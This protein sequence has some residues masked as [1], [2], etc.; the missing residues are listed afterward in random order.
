VLARQAA[1]PSPLAARRW[2]I[3]V[4]ATAV[5]AYALDAMATVAGILLA[6]AQVLQGIG[7]WPLLAALAG[8]YAAW[9]AGLRV[10][11]RANGALL[12]KTGTS[13]NALSKAAYD[14]AT[15]RSLGVNAR[16]LAAAAGYVATEL[17]KEAP[18][19]AGAFGAAVVSDSVASADAIV[20]L[21]GAN[22]GAAVYEYALARGT[23]VVLRRVPGS[24]ADPCAPPIAAAAD[25]AAAVDGYAS[26]DDDWRP[27]EYLAD[28]Y[29][30]V[31]PDEI[32]TI[33]YFVDAM[34][35]VEP[36][37]PVLLFGVGPTLHHVFLA[38]EHASE[39]HLAD[40]LP[41][42]L[43]EIRR[44]IDRDPR[45]HDWRPFVRYTLMCEGDPDPSGADVTR[46][47][48]LT[49]SRIT[50]LLPADARRAHPLGEPATYATVISAYCADSATADRAEWAAFMDRISGL[51]APG[52]TF[53]TAA[54]RRARHYVV[55][56][57]RF[58]S[59]DVDERDLRAVLTPRFSAAV[60]VRALAEHADQGYEG[61]VLAHARRRSAGDAQD[62]VADPD[63]VAGM[64]LAPA[65][66][67]RLAVDGH[68][69]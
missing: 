47:E 67:L 69:R 8:S 25:P 50:R 12:E 59:A 27:G 13:T 52:G 65:P 21:A 49:R 63:F 10:N 57:K 28:Y 24:A 39:I 14:L 53:V 3:T 5:S 54:L 19:Y 11:L 41:A 16:Q 4:A 20:F 62:L 32:E 56:D 22:L 6:G 55:G 40:Y 43:E 26:F 38:A 64:Q 51:V 29:S 18:Y 2:L 31:E 23:R 17:A 48:E 60:E 30:A 15:R 44:W 7:H 66:A 58:P 46:R 34:Q 42:N 68:R 1:V 37:R 35:A 61:I 45:A 33:A 36:A 9:G